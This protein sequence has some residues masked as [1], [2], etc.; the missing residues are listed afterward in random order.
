MTPISG[1]TFPWGSFKGMGYVYLRLDW[2]L[3]TF[4]PGKRGEEE[5]RGQLHEAR[6]W[7]WLQKRV[8]ITAGLPT[9]RFLFEQ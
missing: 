6:G 9:L 5:E 1:K 8:G 4:S 2:T 7:L 3:L